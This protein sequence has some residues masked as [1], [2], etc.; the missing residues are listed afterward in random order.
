MAR[1]QPIPDLAADDRY[2]AAAAKVVRVRSQELFDHAGGVLDIADIERLHDM[3]VA[4]RRL[5]A[6]L[7]VF[8]PCFPERA[9]KRT[10]GEVKG[11]ADALGERRDRDVAIEELGEISARLAG[12]DRRGVESVVAALR[13]E[14]RAANETLAPQVS[15][16]RLVALRERISELIAGAG[17]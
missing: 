2:A 11:L 6:A 15:G 14:Q 7:E 17:S 13:D 10:L 8:G 3:R 1:P 9:H 5:R 4:T 12:P 16:G